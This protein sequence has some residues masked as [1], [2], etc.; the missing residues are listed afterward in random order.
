M[1]D[2]TKYVS[3]KGPNTPEDYV[4][5]VFA[6][7]DEREDSNTQLK[8]LKDLVISSRN[9]TSNTEISEHQNSERAT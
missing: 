7:E 4:L 1:I 2:S 8:Q 6:R 3:R 9:L 5:D